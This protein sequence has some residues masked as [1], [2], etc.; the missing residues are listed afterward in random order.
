MLPDG[1]DEAVLKVAHDGD[2]PLEVGR[3]VSLGN[4]LDK[5]ED[6]VVCLL[7]FPFDQAEE[8]WNGDVVRNNRVEDVQLRISWQHSAEGPIGQ[9]ER[10]R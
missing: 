10:R 1:F 7:I 6:L 8:C 5:L 9:N 2:G 3:P 4:P